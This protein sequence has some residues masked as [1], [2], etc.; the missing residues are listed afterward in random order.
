MHWGSGYKP[1][2]EVLI[3]FGLLWLK[4]TGVI[5]EVWIDS[6]RI[7]VEYPGDDGRVRF[8]KWSGAK[9]LIEQYGGCRWQTRQ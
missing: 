3:A 1:E 7:R 2:E 4:R 6:S 8:L 9:S 5:K